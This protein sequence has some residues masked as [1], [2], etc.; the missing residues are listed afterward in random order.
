ML[1]VEVT[2]DSARSRS[3]ACSRWRD[4]GRAQVHQRVGLA[5]DRVRADHLR[6]SPR[7]RPDLR[8]RRP[9]GAE[10][11]DEGFRGPADGGRVDDGG[12][13]PDDPGGSKPVDP[14][15]DRRGGE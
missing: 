4:V 1:R 13:S 7:G 3:S 14:A 9:A 12:E 2:K 8:R 10:Q 15:L 6:V 5:G 11:L